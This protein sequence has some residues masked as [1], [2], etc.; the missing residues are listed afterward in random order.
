MYKRS[1]LT[2]PMDGIA[3]FRTERLDDV[4]AFYTD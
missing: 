4:V 3:F 1:G 2:T